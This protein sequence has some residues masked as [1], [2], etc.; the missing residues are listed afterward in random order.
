MF[1]V[2]DL[3]VRHPDDYHPFD[4]GDKFHIIIND[5]LSGMEYLLYYAATNHFIR[6]SKDFIEKHFIK[7]EINK[8][9]L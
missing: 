4:K 3:L 6:L 1:K 5:N 7:A 2:G 9:D 8:K